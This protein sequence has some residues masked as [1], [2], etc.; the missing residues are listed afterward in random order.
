[1]RTLRLRKEL[2]F[3]FLKKLRVYDCLIP[4]H[5]TTSLLEEASVGWTAVTVIVIIWTGTTAE[6]SPLKGE[7]QVLS[8][9]YLGHLKSEEIR[10]S[11]H[12]TESHLFLLLTLVKSPKS[13][14][15]LEYFVQ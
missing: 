12:H 9:A 8:S 5:Y 2:S 1:M 11:S 3:L 14:L 13:I 10:R 7:A 15:D 6:R 4:K